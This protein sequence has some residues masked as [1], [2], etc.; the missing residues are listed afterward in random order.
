MSQGVWPQP[1]D[2]QRQLLPEVRLSSFPLGAR[3]P[4]LKKW[5]SGFAFTLS[6]WKHPGAAHCCRGPVLGYAP[7]PQGLLQGPELGPGSHWIRWLGQVRLRQLAPW[8]CPGG[9]WWL[10]WPRRISPWCQMMKQTSSWAA[11]LDLPPGLLWAS[12]ATALSRDLVDSWVPKAWNL[13]S[14]LAG[15]LWGRVST[16]HPAGAVLV[17]PADKALSAFVK[18]CRLTSS[19]A[20]T[21]ELLASA[22]RKGRFGAG[23]PQWPCTGGLP[24]APG[25]SAKGPPSRHS[26]QAPRQ[27]PCHMPSQN[28][29]GLGSLRSFLRE[30]F[31]TFGW[32]INKSPLILNR[33]PS[34]EKSPLAKN[35]KDWQAACWVALRPRAR[36]C[37]LVRDTKPFP[38]QQPREMGEQARTWARLALR[39]KTSKDWTLGGRVGWGGELHLR[40]ARKTF[41][42][43]RALNA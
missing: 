6:P 14:W 37:L 4:D 25:S 13:G 40:V 3:V 31:R 35:G 12:P 1:G 23:R 20:W 8:P 15:E 27:D 19:G 30:T 42:L 32:I 21:V 18:F 9:F 5:L 11:P 26:I 7:E 28:P 39:L 17:Q 38:F 36:G 29:E 10:T 41:V 16:S 33:G 2:L 22:E 34:K 43:A 24:P